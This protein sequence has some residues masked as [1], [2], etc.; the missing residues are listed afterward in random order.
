VRGEVI[1]KK[2]KFKNFYGCSR[3]PDCDWKVGR[4]LNL[5][6]EEGSGFIAAQADCFIDDLNFQN[7]S[8][9]YNL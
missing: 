2:A 1:V 4:I 7:I 8:V 5:K 3:Y 6:K 9:K